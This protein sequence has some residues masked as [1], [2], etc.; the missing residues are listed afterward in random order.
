[1]FLSVEDETGISN[2]I[3][4]PDVFG[5]NRL[6]LVNAPFLFIEGVLQNIDGVISV[7]AT[8]IEPLP[9]WAQTVSHD[10]H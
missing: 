8:R 1:M 9:T 3:V 5:E 2:V 10:F 4:T 6:V 7:K